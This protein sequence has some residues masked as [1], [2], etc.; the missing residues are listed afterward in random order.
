MSP[1]RILFISPG[2]ATRAQMAAGLLQQL[3]GDS[4][5]AASA[6]TTT[7]APPP[8]A[9]RAMAELGIDLGGLPVRTLDQYAGQR[10]DEQILLCDGTTET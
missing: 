6:G 7:S 9:V 2:D 3:A 8:A 1:R 10:F 5:S 4:C